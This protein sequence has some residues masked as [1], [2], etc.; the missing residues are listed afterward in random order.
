[1]KRSLVPLSLLFFILPCCSQD[2]DSLRYPGENHLRNV[3]QL[4][5]G[6]LNAEA[7]FSFDERRLVFQSVRDSFRCD[8]IFTMNTDGSDVRLVSTGKGRTTCAYYLPDGAHVLYASTHLDDPQCPPVPDRKKG[9]V[10]G[11]FR[12]YDIFIADT[13]GTITRRLTDVPGYDAE[14]V[15]SP[16]GDRIAFTSIRGGDLDIYTM[17]LDGSDVRRLT[18]EL[19]YDGGPF[20]SSDGKKIVYRAYHPKTD[21]EVT[22]YK[23]LLAEEKIRPINLQVFLMDADGSNKMQI[24]HNSGTNFAPYLFP[25]GQSVIFSSN[26]ADTLRA[27]F[28]FDLFAVRTDGTGLERVT[29]GPGFEGFPMFTRDGKK[30]VFASS[31]NGKSPYEINVFL[32]D[33]VP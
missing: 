15:V 10:W 22:E 9:Y 3:R 21:S 16:A 20:F 11:L 30:L 29:Y 32:A 2:L 26:L 24:T 14:A 8:Q 7:Y 31:R 33:W 18:H 23:Q 17:N 28:N 4:T 1:M 13:G 5:F 19:G 25:D 27:T 6:G 12:G